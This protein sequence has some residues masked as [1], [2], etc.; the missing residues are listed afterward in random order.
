[1][2]ATT[3][4]IKNR[5]DDDNGRPARALIETPPGGTFLALDNGGGNAG[6]AMGAEDGGVAK[7]GL[8]G[9]LMPPPSI[10]ERDTAPQHSLYSVCNPIQGWKL[11][12]D[13]NA[14]FA[15]PPL[16]L[17]KSIPVNI[18]IEEHAS[19][20]SLQPAGSSFFPSVP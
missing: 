12:S 6:N 3:L 10:G 4:L 15:L 9:L 19:L 1:M 14:P 18:N 13:P 17:H 5:R 11:L 8:D 7:A 2:M 16:G 20:H